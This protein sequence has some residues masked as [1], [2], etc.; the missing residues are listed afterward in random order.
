MHK[1]HIV[2]I[3]LM[4]LVLIQL[5]L[6]VPFSGLNTPAHNPQ[7]YERPRTPNTFFVISK[8]NPFEPFMASNNFMKTSQ[9]SKG[10]PC[11]VGT[12]LTHQ[13]NQ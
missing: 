8:S 1:Y 4:S 12:L 10:Q 5:N 3:A 9:R 13:F 2:C 7:V 11:Q 6:R